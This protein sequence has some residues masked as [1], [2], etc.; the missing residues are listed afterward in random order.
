MA[1]LA[2][3]LVP[4]LSQSRNGYVQVCG[5]TRTFKHC[6]HGNSLPPPAGA[7]G[8][9]GSLRSISCFPPMRPS[10]SLGILTPPTPRPAQGQETERGGRRGAGSPYLVNTAV[11]WLGLVGVYT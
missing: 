8:R 1:L 2:P 6:S 7:W 11:S 5:K 10:G 3:F 9:E 4:A